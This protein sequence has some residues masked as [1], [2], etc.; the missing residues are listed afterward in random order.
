MGKDETAQEVLDAIVGGVFADCGA[1]CW[2]GGTLV[3]Y[4]DR[5]CAT[6]FSL[7]QDQSS[8]VPWFTAIDQVSA[9]VKKRLEAVSFDCAGDFVCGRA[10]IGEIPT[11]CE[12]GPP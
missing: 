6:S 5:G 2:L 10:G 11:I 8:E 1:G 4:F 7:G 3:V 9:C 12:L